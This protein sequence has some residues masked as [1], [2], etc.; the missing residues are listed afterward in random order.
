MAL[1]QSGTDLVVDKT[2]ALEANLDF[3]NGVDFGKGCFVG[4]EV[5]A[6]TK[7]RGLARKRLLP[8]RFEGA[9]L[10]VG[11]EIVADGRAIG[12][13]RS[14]RDGYGLALMRL[15]RLKEAEIAGHDFSVDG[16]PVTIIRP[17]W[18]VGLDGDN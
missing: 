17:D 7:Y 5:T 14:S 6:R 10:P 18:M 1:P 13:T 11:Q 8:I 12:E 16:N 9:G 4:Q 15:D 3:L 2:I